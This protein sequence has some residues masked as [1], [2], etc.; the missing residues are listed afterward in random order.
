M[1]STAGQSDSTS[2]VLYAQP[3]DISATGF[4]FH[5]YAEYRSKAKTCRNAYGDP[6]E[7]YDL[8]FIDGE[9]IDCALAA[10]IGLTQANCKAFFEAVRSWDDDDDKLRVIIAVGDCG[11][12]FDDSTK[13]DDFDVDIYDVESFVEL[14][15]LF[16]DEG[17]FGSLGDLP[18]A[19]IDFQAIARDLTI[20]YSELE[21]DGR[22][23]IYRCG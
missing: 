7:E 5:D 1:P 9:P 2:L 22:T 4:Y 12:S 8:Q 20:D 19:Y 13:A 14:A 11:Y 10:A 6:V 18:Y 21:I 16:I 17:V 15:Q 3:Y 23:I